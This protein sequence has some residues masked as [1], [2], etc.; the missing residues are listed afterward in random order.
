MGYREAL[1]LPITTFWLLS[2]SINRLM[3]EK[4]IRSLSVAG[5]ASSEKG[6]KK[7][8]ESLQKEMGDIVINEAPEAVGMEHMAD[9]VAKL[10]NR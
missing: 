10:S 1:D 3:A 4:D 5:A 9:F 2:N 7:A 6:F 8:Q